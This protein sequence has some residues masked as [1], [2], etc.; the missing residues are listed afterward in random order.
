MS[1][2]VQVEQIAYAAVEAVEHYFP[3]RSSLE[4]TMII[5]VFMSNLMRVFHPTPS[6]SSVLGQK[7]YLCENV[8]LK[9]ETI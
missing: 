3:I 7:N 4:I 6:D 5:D 1:K 9:K 8:K 2:P